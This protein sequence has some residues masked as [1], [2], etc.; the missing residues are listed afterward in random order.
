VKLTV[1]PETPEQAADALIEDG[2]L[3]VV[4]FPSL[5]ADALQGIPGKIVDAVLPHTEAHPA[6]VLVQVLAR[7]GA[8]AGGSLHVRADNRRH[9]ARIYPLIV[10]KTSDGAKGTSDQVAAALSAAAERMSSSPWPMRQLSGLSSGEGLIEAVR[11]PN[12]DD[13]SAKG[14]DEGITDKRLLVIESEF[15]S[16]LAV[17]ER[18]GSTLPRV[19]REA[20]DGDVLRTMSRHSPLAATGAHIVIIGHVTPGE[21]RIR[22]KEAQLVGG[23]MN[24]FLPVASRRTKLRPDGGNIPEE[25]LDEFGAHLAGSLDHGW[26]AS[27]IERTGAADRLWRAQY[28]HLRR[29][30]PDGQVA[31]MLARGVPQ[32]LRLSLVYAL[33]DGSG[34]IDEPHLRA[35]L[36]L[37]TYAEDTAEWMFGTE[38]DTGEVED[39][40]AF[41]AAG[42]TRG[43]TRTEI[44]SGHF[45][46]HR[47][48]DEI[49]AML[50]PLIKDGRV[51]QVTDQTA[52]RPATRYCAT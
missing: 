48:A 47:K 12:G 4:P 39:L 49:E 52:G 26:S 5:H 38:V 19:V 24:R 51:H 46:R 40:V 6:A 9:P 21:L 35:A 18:Q 41:I 44:S 20:W 8:L 13:P 22:L 10:G 14:F 17:M 2:P 7:F 33:A 42:G 36:A 25:I 23:T 27:R 30:R 50:T 29:S 28:P 43:R 32:V 16:M 31:S 15:T 3:S 34:V 37:W 11:D 45:Q 1:T